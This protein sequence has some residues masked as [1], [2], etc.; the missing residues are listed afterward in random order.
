M[1]KI[2]AFPIIVFS[3]L[4]FL[5]AILASFTVY[6]MFSFIDNTDLFAVFIVWLPLFYC[7]V[8]IIHRI[9]LK[10]YPL[11]EGYVESGSRLEFAYHVYI[12]FYLVLLYSLIRTKIIPV[13]FQ[14]MIYIA[15]GAKLGENTYC[16]GTI[17]D[18]VLTIAGSNTIIGEDSLLFSHAI[19]GDHLSHKFI[20]IGNN[21]TIGAKSILMSGVVVGDNAIV[22]AGSV[23]LKNTV[24]GDNEIWGGN[25]AK[26]IKNVN[27][28]TL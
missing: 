17:L 13:P 3:M 12:L 14:R 21:V 18:P 2:T 19:E 26:L 16:S 10:F 6:I 5:S 1:R 22:A 20:K 4:I 11:K 25:P 7:F 23:V 28:I 15:L 27:K 24:I 9:F 8:I